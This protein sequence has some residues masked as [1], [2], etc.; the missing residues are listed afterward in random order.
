MHIMVFTNKHILNNDLFLMDFIC[1]YMHILTFNCREKTLTKVKL[2]L[3]LYV[4]D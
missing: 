3:V 2:E 1:T 4:T